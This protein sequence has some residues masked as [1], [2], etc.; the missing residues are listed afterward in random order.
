L[1][2]EERDIKLFEL[3][4]KARKNAYVP[5][6]GFAVGAALLT[7]SGEIFTGC[8]VENSS[9]GATICAERTAMVK[10]VSEGYRNFEA[11]AISGG[12]AD[13]EG[14][15]AWPCGICR[16]FMLEFNP[17]IRVITGNDEES[18]EALP[19]KELLLHGFTL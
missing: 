16:Q 9:Y 13:S 10:A 4:R 15:Q 7:E 19:V 2:I 1:K 3:A 5:Y 12:P 14:S 11:I 17:D 6:S 18:L 8:N